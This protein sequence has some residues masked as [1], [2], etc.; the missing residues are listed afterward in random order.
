MSCICTDGVKEVRNVMTRNTV[1][2]LETFREKFWVNR[3]GSVI[4]CLKFSSSIVKMFGMFVVRLSH[5]DNDDDHLLLLLLLQYTVSNTLSIFLLNGTRVDKYW[6][7]PFTLSSKYVSSSPRK[8][9]TLFPVFV[10]SHVCPVIVHF[11]LNELH[12]T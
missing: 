3:C 6:S 7:L 9:I 11:C 10:R 5:Y 1:M 12:D 4:I 2:K 8:C